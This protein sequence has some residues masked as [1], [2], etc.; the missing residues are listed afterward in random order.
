MGPGVGCIED[1]ESEAAHNVGELE[2][3][4]RGAGIPSL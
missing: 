4:V 3:G 2:F 1:R